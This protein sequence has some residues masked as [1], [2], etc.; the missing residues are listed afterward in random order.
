MFRE[1]QREGAQDEKKS[2]LYKLIMAGMAASNAA[3]ILH[4]TD[5]CI[6][7]SVIDGFFDSR[8]LAIHVVH[9]VDVM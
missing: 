6:A 2:E 4:A 8:D 1:D 7:E 5:L 3:L 9:S